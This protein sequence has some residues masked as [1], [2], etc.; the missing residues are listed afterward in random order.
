MHEIKNN[1]NAPTAPT[2]APT[3]ED[4]VEHGE[5]SQSISFKGLLTNKLLAALPARDFQRLLPGLEPVRLTASKNLY[6]FGEE[7]QYA[8]FPEDAVI[9]QLYLLTDGATTETAII[10]RE[11]MIGLSTLLTPNQPTYLMKVLVAGSALRMKIDVLKDEF[12]RGDAVQRLLFAYAGAR[13]AQTSQ[14][15]VCNGRHKVDERLCCW[16][17]LVNER[18]GG[19]ELTLTHEQI[20]HH[21]GVRR[22]GVTRVANALRE[23]G[24]ISYCR[25]VIRILDIP[26]LSAAACECYHVLKTK[27]ELK[28]Y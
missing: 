10:G 12:K 3:N 27:T 23:K 20:A 26:S 22:A 7:I 15:A 25:G 4:S 18:A 11:G 14:K 1:L 28:I 21:L 17:L 2:R 8:Y 19:N 16:L 6:G 13:I 9:S 24:I 5:Q